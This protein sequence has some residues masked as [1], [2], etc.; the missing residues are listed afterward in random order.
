MR[1]DIRLAPRV[2]LPR[3]PANRRKREHRLTQGD[4]EAA[5]TRHWTKR[6]LVTM[7]ALVG[8]LIF[9]SAASAS[10]IYDSSSTLSVQFGTLPPLV[11]T[12][13]GGTASVNGGAGGPVG[14]A[15]G[16]FMG[17]ALITL[18]PTVVPPLTALSLINGGNL[19]GTRSFRA[20]AAPSGSSARSTPTWAVSLCW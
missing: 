17:S 11:L 4:R 16:D 5:R 13:P 2:S 3:T 20:W 9:T 18:P 8:V 19:G 1:K 14:L 12:S 10:L 15:G 6:T 7:V